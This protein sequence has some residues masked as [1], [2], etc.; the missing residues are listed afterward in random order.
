M[1]VKDWSTTAASNT[2]VGGISIAEGWSPSNV[3]NAIREMMAQL[4]DYLHMSVIPV[5]DY[6][7]TGDGVTQEGALLNTALETINNLGAAAF[8]PGGGKVYLCEETILF[9]PQ[10]TVIFAGNPVIR[11]DATGTFTRTK[12][13]VGANVTIDTTAIY[14]LTD[15]TGA[16]RCRTVGSAWIDCNNVTGLCGF[17]ATQN[18]SSGNCENSVFDSFYITNAF[19]AVLGQTIG[20]VAT[21]STFHCIRTEN[22]IYDYWSEGNPFDDCT[23]NTFRTGENNTLAATQGAVIYMANSEYGPVFNQLF[24]RPSAKAVGTY[25]KAGITLA[26]NASLNANRIYF[27]AEALHGISMG[28]NCS[29]HVGEMKTSPT[30]LTKPDADAHS[31]LVTSSVQ[32]GNIHVTVDSRISAPSLDCIVKLFC[33]SAVAWRRNV[34]VV[35]PVSRSTIPAVIY[36]GGNPSSG[37][38]V[39]ADYPGERVRYYYS[40][41]STLIAHETFNGETATTHTVASAIDLDLAIDSYSERRHENVRREINNTGGNRAV[42]LVAPTAADIGR[43]VT[44]VLDTAGA[45]PGNMTLTQNTGVYPAFATSWCITDTGADITV[46][47]GNVAV[48]NMVCVNDGTT[49]FW[50]V[51]SKINPLA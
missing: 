46:T 40:G 5:T 11:A 18:P 10:S 39:I 44:L 21:G 8:I 37:D 35:S 45:S 38:L 15:F 28:N 50:T 19:A 51:S 29:L 6:G 16:T 49:Q 1:A 13:F 47:S 3:N 25:Y 26:N 32:T 22:C 34:H 31:P 12:D 20:P 4:A 24:V 42:R 43:R 9:Q 48:F 36:G 41:T 14:G 2:A 7:I 30:F 27:E 33:G 17:T 23:F